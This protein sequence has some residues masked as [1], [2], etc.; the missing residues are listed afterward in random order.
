MDKIMLTSQIKYRYKK[1][2]KKRLCQGDILRGVEFKIG[3]SNYGGKSDTVG[4]KYAVVMSQDC[5]IN[6][7]F[8]NKEKKKSNP[9]ADDDK[10]L[11]TILVCPAYISGEFYIGSHINGWSMKPFSKKEIE[12]LMK[13]DEYKRY[14]YLH[15][16]NDLGIPELIIDFKH[17][18]TLP[19]GL[20]YKYKKTSYISTISEVFREELSQRFAGYL[21]RFGL[22]DLK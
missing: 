9:D 11:P 12:K 20:L 21:S 16:N 13:N 5:D 10:F 6:S 15:Q 18:F 1:I 4:L 22:P 17:F 7:D 14:H 3:D 8:L 19:V 2:N